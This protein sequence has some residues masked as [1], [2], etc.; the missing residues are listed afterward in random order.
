MRIVTLIPSATEIVCA[1]D[2]RTQLVGVSHECDYPPSV[3]ELPRVT[4][5]L[6][7]HHAPS[8]QIDGQVRQELAQLN[9]LYSLKA[10]L[11]ERLKPDLI[12]MQS[13]CDVCAVADDEVRAFADAAD[14]V[15]QVLNIEPLTLGDVMDTVSAIGN[16]TGTANEV[17]HLV[18]TMRERIQ[19]VSTRTAREIQNSEKRRVAFLEW[20]DPPFCGGHWNP[21]L[22][23]LAGG[24]D[25]LGRAGQASATVTV[26]AITRADPDVLFIACCGFTLDRS[27]SET[28]QILARPQWQLMRAV[29]E[30]QVYVVDGNAYFSRPGPRLVDSVEI[31]AHALYPTIHPAG[32]ASAIVPELPVGA[33]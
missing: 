6:I 1:L 5:T 15:P 21:E 13:L 33:Y 23:A 3:V 19:V 12:V 20:I 18:R 26:D 2:L 8:A 10:E 7:D 11:L 31:I 16:A 4:T 30:R 25:C 14:H 32:P 29:R 17:A 27:L 24:I 28:A 22:V 9:A